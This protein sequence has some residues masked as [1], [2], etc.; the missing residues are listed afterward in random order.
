MSTFA[1]IYDS[2]VLYP[3]PL[4]D[5]L[6][7]LALADLFRA[8]WT[9]EI[10]EE[11]IRNLLI[12]R[13]EIKREQLEKIRDMMNMHVR[14][15]L[16]DDYQQLIETLSLPD[17]NDRHILAAAIHSG[18]SSIIT[19]NLKDFPKSVLEKYNIE[20]QHPD[21]FL[22]TLLDLSSDIFLSTIK[23]HRMIL[24]NP[25]KTIDEYLETLKKQSL[26]KTVGEL[27]KFREYL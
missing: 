16:V 27:E 12:N 9:N 20:A 15:C 4:R 23:M 14:D 24:K 6:M 1:V 7:R 2:C 22:M 25:S 10:H 19:Y 21:D 18:C 26:I 13:T 5:L 17:P 8:K 11:W 3:A